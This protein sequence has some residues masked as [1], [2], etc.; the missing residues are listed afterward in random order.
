MRLFQSALPV[1]PTFFSSSIAAAQFFSAMR[2]R[3]APSLSELS[4]VD[5]V[6]AAKLA[7][8]TS[9]RSGASSKRGV[10]MFMGDPLVV[11]GVEGA[12]S[13]AFRPVREP[14]SAAAGR[15]ATRI[16]PLLFVRPAMPR[17]PAYCAIDFGTSNSAIAVPRPGRAMRL[18]ELEPGYPTMPTAVFYAAEGGAHARPR[19]EFGR[20]AVAAYVDGIDGRL[21]RSMKSILGSTLIEQT[22]D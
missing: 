13:I 7:A 16:A 22:T 11:K 15:G 8:A 14:R 9:S 4:G 17:P 2:A 21:M 5:Q 6:S 10:D 3:A 12:T 20:A 19:C 1:S 18:V